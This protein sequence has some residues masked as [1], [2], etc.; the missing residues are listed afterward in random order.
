MSTAV[1]D[2]WEEEAASMLWRV[3]VGKFKGHMLFTI[4]MVNSS[5]IQWAADNWDREEQR[6]IFRMALD[7][8]TAWDDEFH[9]IRHGQS[10][11]DKLPGEPKPEQVPPPF[12]WRDG[13]NTPSRT[14]RSSGHA[15]QPP[16]ITEDVYER[17]ENGDFDEEF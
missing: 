13:N 8:L 7:A 11:E 17:F 14:D 16:A 6:E 1:S 3:P 10:V 2:I 5:Y 9:A 12:P 15:L 4:W